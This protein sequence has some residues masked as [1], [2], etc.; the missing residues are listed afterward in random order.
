MPEPDMEELNDPNAPHKRHEGKRL[1]SPTQITAYKECPRKWYYQYVLRIPIPEKFALLRGTVVHSVCEHLF[2][3][4]PTPGWSFDELVEHMT[5]TA[6]SI[7]KD[8]WDEKKITEKFGDDH[9]EETVGIIDKFL[10]RHEWK[11]EP[12]YKKFHDASKAW[13][14]SKPK[15]SERRVIDEELGVQGIIDAVIETDPGEIVL[16]DYKTSS[17]FKHPISHEYRTQ[18][19]IYALLFEKETGL[20]PLYVSV[21]YLLYGQVSNY[22]V[23][24]DLLEETRTLIQDIYKKTGSKEISDYPTNTEFKF[25][26]WCDFRETCQGQKPL[27]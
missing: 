24:Q 25:C 3:W 10:K 9:Y 4:R 23:T 16:V 1:L 17:F 13:N 18:L 27:S 14:F 2:R 15:Y 12:L 11:M 21:D 26:K 7:L 22:P 19:Y 20:R 5:T 6:H 8:A